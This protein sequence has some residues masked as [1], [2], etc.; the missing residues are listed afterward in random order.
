MNS[1]K[2]QNRNEM[3]LSTIEFIKLSK[4]LLSILNQ[5]INRGNG[6]TQE[7]ANAGI[8][9]IRTFQKSK[10]DPQVFVKTFNNTIVIKAFQTFNCIAGRQSHRD[11][12]VKVFIDDVEIFLAEQ[13]NI[14]LN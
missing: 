6:I 5:L 10:L 3:L 8:H 11:R 1:E 4:D 7:E 9:I 14:R 13:E 12:V 2:I